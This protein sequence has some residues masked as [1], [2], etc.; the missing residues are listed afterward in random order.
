MANTPITK[1]ANIFSKM[2]NP[3]RMLTKPQIERMVNDWHHGDDVRMQ[4]VFS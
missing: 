3:L 1:V 4:L 2:F